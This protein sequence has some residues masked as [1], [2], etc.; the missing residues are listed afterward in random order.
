MLIE[1]PFSLGI[2]LLD[3]VEHTL[4]TVMK[5][6]PHN[7]LWLWTHNRTRLR[8]SLETSYRDVSFRVCGLFAEN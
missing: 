7:K 2:V 3:G 1:F 6:N 5:E 8:W 4:N